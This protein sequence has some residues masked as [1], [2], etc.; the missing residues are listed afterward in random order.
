MLGHEIFEED[1]ARR[2][3]ARKLKKNR[4]RQAD[5]LQEMHMK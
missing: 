1:A 2:E 5:R 4:L 3:T